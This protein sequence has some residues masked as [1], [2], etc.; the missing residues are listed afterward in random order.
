M[1]C[2]LIIK[3]Y[4]VHELCMMPRSNFLWIEKIFRCVHIIQCMV[5][6]RKERGRICVREIGGERIYE[7]KI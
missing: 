7:R 5:E 1:I 6:K 4:C 3:Q 2:Q